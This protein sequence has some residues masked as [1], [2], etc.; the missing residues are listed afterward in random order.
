MK[1]IRVAGVGDPRTDLGIDIGARD[2]SGALAVAKS[3]K[4]TPEP[5]HVVLRQPPAARVAIEGDN[6]KQ[7]DFCRFG[8]GECGASNRFGTAKSGQSL[9]KHYNELAP[10]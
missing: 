8:A 3:A 5:R 4:A 6:Q 1:G 2:R 7:A 9:S 10:E